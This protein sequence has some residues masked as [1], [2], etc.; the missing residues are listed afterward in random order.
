MPVNPY[1]NFKGNCRQA[2][3]Y[4]TE[5]FGTEKPQIMTFGEMP[6]DPSSSPMPDNVKALVA[7]T[8]INFNGSI[9]M[10]SDVTPNMPLIVGNNV[11][12]MISSKDPEEIRGFYNKMKVGSAVQMEL[13][14]TFWAKCYGSLIDKFGIAWQFNCDK[15]MQQQY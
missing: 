10:F 11:S 2:V 8:S 1:V 7:H 14:E 13:Q 6:A 9:V 4:Y 3:N 5:V 12:I 15:E